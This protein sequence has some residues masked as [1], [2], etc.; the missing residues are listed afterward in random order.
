M[1]TAEE[2]ITP[3]F[4]ETNQIVSSES[5]EAKQLAG[6]MQA[7][8]QQLL[9]K[10]YDPE[11]H[12]FTFLFSDNPDVEGFIIPT[13]K[14][15]IIVTSTGLINGS[16][17]IDEIAGYLGHELGHLNIQEKYGK[18]R[19]ANSKAEEM[20]ADL[21]SMKLINE[22]GYSLQGISDLL[23][24]CDDD[25][26]AYTALVDVHPLTKTR[27]SIMDKAKSLAA[28]DGYD[29]SKPSQALPSIW[30]EATAKL[31]YL[32]ILE[33]EKISIGYD[34]LNSEEKLQWLRKKVEGL[35]EA[36]VEGSEGKTNYNI[37]K[38]RANELLQ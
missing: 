8:T 19:E 4:L 29:I 37:F 2:I 33:Q 14:P 7:L 1:P 26:P 36:S 38:V 15:P 5:I 25:V 16:K 9:G 12:Q 3:A 24:R 13:A 6:Q 27:L 22:A 18:A 35:K 23:K 10:R 31:S 20:G 28:R 30:K 21:Y 11:K 17:T 34:G 32:S